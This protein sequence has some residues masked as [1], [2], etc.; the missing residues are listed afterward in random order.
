MHRVDK[1]DEDAIP[2]AAGLV[3]QAGEG[4]A[5]VCA[6]EVE[7]GRAPLA[8]A[9]RRRQEA[10]H[11]AARA[12]EFLRKARLGRSVVYRAGNVGPHPDQIEVFEEWPVE[13][14]HPDDGLLVVIAV[15]V[16]GSGRREN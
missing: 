4:A 11:Q 3:A 10:W 15:A 13:Y 5:H 2:R 1:L 8:A 7:H 6:P 9:P 12:V 14:V 16:P